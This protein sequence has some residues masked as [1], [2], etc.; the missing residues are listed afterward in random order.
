MPPTDDQTPAPVHPPRGVVGGP[1][2]V[3]AD[4][5]REDLA[6]GAP[7]SRAKDELI[8]VLARSVRA[9]KDEAVA[10]LRW[11]TGGETLA[12]ADNL[13]TAIYR[14]TNARTAALDLL[15]RAGVAS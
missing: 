2:A 3:H 1:L 13:R 4:D 15:A 7:S 9:S 6:S 11:L 10:R 14:A 12:D 5:L 8:A